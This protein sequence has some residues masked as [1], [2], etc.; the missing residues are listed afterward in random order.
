MTR[1][2]VL[3]LALAPLALAGCSPTQ[4]V[5]PDK[6]V[7]NLEQDQA[8][9]SRLAR[10]QSQQYAA[11]SSPWPTTSRP[12]REGGGVA[13]SDDTMASAARRDPYLD[14]ARLANDCMQ[15]RGYRLMPVAS[16]Q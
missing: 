7:A 15:A 9:C 2:I 5:H 1:S 12:Y 10:N 11:A 4:W 16:N 14:E 8:E 6:G 3:A 13:Q